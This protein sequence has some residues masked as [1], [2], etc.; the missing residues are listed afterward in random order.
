MLKYAICK[1]FHVPIFF[2]IKNESSLNNSPVILFYFYF[3]LLHLNE[4]FCKIT[5]PF[6]YLATHL[7]CILHLRVD[8]TLG[9]SGGSN[10]SS[11]N[12]SMASV[13]YCHQLL[14]L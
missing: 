1:M 7:T 13:S 6:L 2:I 9:E 5:G 10:A 12:F 4:G 3:F 14:H 8:L 11:S